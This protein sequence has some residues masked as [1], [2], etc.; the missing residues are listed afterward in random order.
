[1][2]VTC[3]TKAFNETFPE[4]FGVPKEVGSEIV[5]GNFPGFAED[6]MVDLWSTLE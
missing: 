6:Q 1:L 3:L 4:L 2:Y 5:F